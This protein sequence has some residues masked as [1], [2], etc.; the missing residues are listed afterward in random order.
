MSFILI[1]I[2][3]YFILS[4]VNIADKFLLGNVIPNSKAYTFLVGVL[5][6]V[7]LVIAPWFLVWPGINL[8]FLNL[9]IG[10]LFPVA[11]LFLYK[12][13]KE[14]D[15]SKIITLV[16]GAIPIF[17]IFFS[18]VLFQERF[19]GQQWLGIGLLLIGTII[20]SWIP[21]KKNLWHKFAIWFGLT[22]DDPFQGIF[23]ALLSALFFTIFF[24]GS[25]F[26]YNEQPFLS[27]F[28]WIRFGSFLAVLFL[29]I[30]KKERQEILQSIKKLFKHQGKVLFFANQG[31][32]AGGALLQNY[33]IALGSVV[34]VN[35][36]Q[37]VQYVFLLILG[38]IITILKPQA[39]KEN[40]SKSIII[41]KIIAILLIGLGLYFIS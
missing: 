30:N 7:V 10:L 13:L 1:A 5:G 31:L 27:G 6:L 21:N 38:V 8:F 34:I 4:I 17:T 12:S 39:V 3:A 36:L 23:T 32:A 20:I 24:I 19:T 29:L 35:A 28:I 22:K 40:I 2:L 11:L 33:A 15:T 18:V 41:Q 16:G 14:G 9:I 26:L 37:G 25:K